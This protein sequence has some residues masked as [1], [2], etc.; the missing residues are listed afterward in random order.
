M[1]VYVLVEH[2]ADEQRELGCYSTQALAE[3]AAAG[4]TKRSPIRWDFTVMAYELDSPPG[5][6]EICS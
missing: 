3:A 6:G 4:I 1:I 5:Q 2:S